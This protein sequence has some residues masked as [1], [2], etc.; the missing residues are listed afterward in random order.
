MPNGNGIQVYGGRDFVLRIM[1]W[2]LEFRDTALMLFSSFS[3]VTLDQGSCFVLNKLHRLLSSIILTNH[4][5]FR[6]HVC[7]NILVLD[8]T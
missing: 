1:T 5:Q 4:N 8:N 7:Y 3:F 2:C 6:S